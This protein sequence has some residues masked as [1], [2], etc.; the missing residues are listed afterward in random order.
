LI[1]NLSGTTEKSN[2]TQKY[3]SGSVPTFVAEI[4]TPNIRGL[5]GMAFNVSIKYNENATIIQIIKITLH[6][7]SEWWAY[8]TWIS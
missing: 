8:F 1:I 4:S 2:M 6:S 7:F 5:L 3:F